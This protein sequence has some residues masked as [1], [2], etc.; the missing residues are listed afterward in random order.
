MAESRLTLADRAAFVIGTWFGCGEVPL[1]PG[2]MGAIGAIPVHL[3]LCHLGLGWHAAV[4]LFI[5][6]IGTW[7]SERI[8]VVLAMED[9]Q[10]VVVDEVAGVLISMAFV[11]DAGTVPVV[12]AFLLFRFFDITKPGPIRKAEHAQ[13]PGFGVMADDLLAGLAG[14]IVAKAGVLIAAALHH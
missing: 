3:W 5:T 6:A 7:A 8:C 12:C 14:G 4:I 2:T 13:P 9:P 11:R 10:R 1:A